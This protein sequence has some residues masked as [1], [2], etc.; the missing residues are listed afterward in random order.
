ML[1]NANYILSEIKLLALWKIVW[2]STN[3]A[4]K[5]NINNVK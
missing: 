5:Y 1:L 4:L 2:D 3:P